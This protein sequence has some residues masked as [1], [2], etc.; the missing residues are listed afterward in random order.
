MYRELT[1]I[2]GVA[3]VA[4]VAVNHLVAGGP[5]DRAQVSGA[6]SAGAG[7][8][9]VRGEIR[10]VPLPAGFAVPVIE[11]IRMDADTTGLLEPMDGLESEWP[12]DAA[13]MTDELLQGD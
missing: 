11:E 8:A 10:Y 9:I 13:G 1:V 2:V 6:S 4:A 5:I 12:A 3:A 7:S